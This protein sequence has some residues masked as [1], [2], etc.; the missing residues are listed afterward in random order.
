MA[1]GHEPVELRP[2]PFGIAVARTAQADAAV[3]T[4]LI[5]DTLAAMRVQAV[6]R[7]I[8]QV[9]AVLAAQSQEYV[10]RLDRIIAIA[11]EVWGEGCVGRLRPG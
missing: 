2:T 10:M 3:L 4:A 6:E 7:A 9:R 11:T 5:D 1:A 8:G